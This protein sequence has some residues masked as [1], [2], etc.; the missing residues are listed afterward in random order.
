M[1]EMQ[2]YTTQLV[3]IALIRTYMLKRRLLPI[4]I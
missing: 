1:I 3:L 4:E 2:I